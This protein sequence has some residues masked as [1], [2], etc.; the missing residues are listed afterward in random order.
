[1][2][3]KYDAMFAKHKALIQSLDDEELSMLYVRIREQIWSKDFR[4]SLEES[5]G[6]YA[7]RFGVDDAHPVTDEELDRMVRSYRFAIQDELDYIL[8]RIQRQCIE[9]V[10]VERPL[11]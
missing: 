4:L 10:L 3:D 8:D 11:R 2:A 6:Y 1:M 9:D 7:E 5:K